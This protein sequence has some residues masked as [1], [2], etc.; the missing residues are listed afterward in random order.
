MKNSELFALTKAHIDISDPYNPELWIKH[1]GKIK[2]DRKVAL[3]ARFIQAYE[4]YLEKYPVDNVLFPITDRFV[5]MVFAELKKQTGITKELTPKTL[6]HT[7]VVRA[8]KRGENIQKIFDR[9]G[10]A[11]ASR[12]EAGEMYFKM[13][14]RGI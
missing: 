3:P 6:R 12:Q 1:T 2:K 14:G 7:H 9:L 13:A 11:E 8:I 5:Q 4:K 10:L